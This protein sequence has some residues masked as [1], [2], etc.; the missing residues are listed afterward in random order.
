MQYVWFE[1]FLF[2]WMYVKPWSG[3]NEQ[4]Y[5]SII[6]IFNQNRKTLTNTPPTENTYSKYE[7]GIMVLGTYIFMHN[8]P[9]QVLKQL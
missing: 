8:F 6:T 1:Y 9:L 5:Y 7:I 4:L 2:C 3:Y